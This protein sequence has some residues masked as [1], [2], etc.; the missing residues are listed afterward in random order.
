MSQDPKFLEAVERAKMI[1]A[2]IQREAAGAAP[3]SAS[4]VKRS[5]DG[6]CVFVRNS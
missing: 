1:A 2:K 4:A 3:T 6:K 5:H